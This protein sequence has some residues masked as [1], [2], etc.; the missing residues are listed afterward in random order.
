MG[1]KL[2]V[3]SGYSGAGKDLELLEISADGIFRQ[4]DSCIHGE[5]P[6]FCCAIGDQIYVA[7]ECS[8]MAE[9]AWYRQKEGKLEF[10][11]RVQVP[12][13]GLCHLYPYREMIYGSCFE[14]GHYFAMDGQSGEI[15]WEF[16]PEKE[17]ARG[18]W[19]QEQNGVLLLADLGN[20]C[21]Y[22][23]EVQDR[24]PR[25]N[26]EVLRMPYGSGPRQALPLPDG[27][28]VAV[29]ELDGMLRI[30]KQ[31]YPVWEGPASKGQK[32]NWP[33]GACLTGEGIL[34]VGNRGPNTVSAFS[35]TGKIPEYLGE[36]STGDWPRHL[37]W[38]PEEKILLVAC[39]KSGEVDLYKWD[40]LRRS[41][42]QTGKILLE[43]ASCICPLS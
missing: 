31:G 21:F 30:L 25:G 24:L 26:P 34:F 10:C 17:G 18:H 1:G 33:G 28:M 14:S 16:L 36:W 39:T 27:Q 19:T 41:L 40:T 8:D 35:V 22:Q 12:G 6:S 32:K 3:I 5:N 9:I 37:A 15:L 42:F 4:L 43:Q 38:M 23:F 11:K 13:R 2:V 7:S 29:C 20:D